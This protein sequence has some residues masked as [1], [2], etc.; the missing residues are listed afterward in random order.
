MTRDAFRPYTAMPI[1]KKPTICKRKQ[2]IRYQCHL[3][4]SMLNLINS[5]HRGCS[6]QSAHFWSTKNLHT[7]LANY[8]PNKIALSILFYHSKQKYKFN[9]FMPQCRMNQFQCELKFLPPAAT[10][11]SVQISQSDKE[12]Q[13]FVTLCY[14]PGFVELRVLIQKVFVAGVMT[15]QLSNFFFFYVYLVPT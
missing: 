3:G 6:M 8:F 15:F 1:S 13:N 12:Y 11:D 14:V 5:R 9:L 7:F 10:G 2:C 4:K